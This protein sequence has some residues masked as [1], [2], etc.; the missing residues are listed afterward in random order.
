M[1]LQGVEVRILKVC[2]QLLALVEIRIEGPLLLV[3]VG[4]LDDHLSRWLQLGVIGIHSLPAAHKHGRIAVPHV[5]SDLDVWSVALGV[6]AFEAIVANA[7]GSLTTT[8]RK[9]WSATGSLGI[10]RLLLLL[11]DRNMGT[12]EQ[13]LRLDVAMQG[14]HVRLR[15]WMAMLRLVEDLRIVLLDV[16]LGA[17]VGD[18]GLW[19]C[20][21]NGHSLSSPS[22][23]KEAGAPDR[24]VRIYIW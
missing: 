23:G 9:R 11:W 8:W 6:E 17:E 3:F 20:P 15:A 13:L 7:M 19:L 22:S 2:W 10:W 21:A 24:L 4:A 18:D 5:G 16:L 1:S 12:L 14:L